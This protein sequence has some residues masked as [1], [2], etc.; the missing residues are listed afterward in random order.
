ESEERD[1]IRGDTVVARFDPPAPDDTTNTPRPREM[2]ATGSAHSFYQLP[3]TGRCVTRP[4]ANYVRGRQLTVRF[5]EN[6]VTT[7][8]VLQA[9]D[10]VSGVYLEPDPDPECLARLAEPQSPPANPPPE[11]DR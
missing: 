5:R 8:S 9:D 3:A 6:E 1:W 2:V 4:A 10:P 7:V 11:V